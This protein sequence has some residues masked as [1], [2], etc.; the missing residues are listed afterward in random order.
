MEA[1]I[2]ENGQSVSVEVADAEKRLAEIL[3]D[4][5]PDRIGL[6][7]TPEATNEEIFEF[8]RLAEKVLETKHFAYGMVPPEEGK[9]DFLRS[10]DKFPNSA[11]ARRIGEN[12]GLGF[13]G[14]KL[15]EKAEKG[16]LD[17]LVLIHPHSVIKC[18]NGDALQ[19]RLAEA[20]GR[21]KTSIVIDYLRSP[22]S[23]AATF[24][25]PA[26][27]HAEKTGTIDN[28]RGMTQRLRR[29]IQPTPGHTPEHEILLRV[30]TAIIEKRRLGAA[31]S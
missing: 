24:L 19:K 7:I 8:R 27:A 2:R 18:P 23:D 6:L 12:S 31:V 15:V 5:A 13:D 11:G 3:N 10:R 20:I 1:A 25:I 29:A 14:V 30:S 17:A 28:S 21:V 4:A 16:E 9:L 26:L 22:V